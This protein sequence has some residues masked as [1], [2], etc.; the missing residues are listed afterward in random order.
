M[1]SNVPYWRLAPVKS[2]CQNPALDTIPCRLTLRILVRE[3]SVAGYVEPR[4]TVRRSTPIMVASTISTPVRFVRVSVAP[5]QLVRHSNAPERLASV[6]LAL[7]KSVPLRLSPLKFCPC[8][9]QPAK[10]LFCVRTLQ[11]LLAT[12]VNVVDGVSEVVNV[13]VRDGV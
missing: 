10:L 11:S 5:P 13:G 9:S 12:G 6:R 4:I 3:N 8:K 7:R 1:L 2:T